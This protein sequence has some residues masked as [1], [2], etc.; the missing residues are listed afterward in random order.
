MVGGSAQVKLRCLKSFGVQSVIIKSIV[1][2][3]TQI[4]IISNCSQ[5]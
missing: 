1:A 5:L 4:I 2:A 3:T